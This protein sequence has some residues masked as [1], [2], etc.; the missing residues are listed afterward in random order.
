MTPPVASLATA[1]HATRLMFFALGLMTGTWGVHIPDLKTHYGLGAGSLSVVLLAAAAG[2]VL[3]LLVAGRVVQ[4]LGARGAALGAGVLVCLTVG[5]VLLPATYGALMLL[6]LVFG[7]GGAL[8]DV[9][10]NAEGS[11]LEA[12]SPR[13]IMSGLH[14]MF[15]VGGMSGAALGALLGRAGWTADVQLPVVAGLGALAVLI[16]CRGMLPVHPPAPAA[17]PDD[18]AG[19]PAQAPATV[20]RWLAVLCALGMLAEGAMYD[21]SVLYLA[22]DLG[23][24][25]DLAAWG[26]AS[27]SAAMAVARFGGD[28]VR[29]RVPAGRLLGLSAGL[30]AVAMAVVLLA[31]RVDVALVGYALA[32]VGL[33]NVVPILF[34]AAANVP[35][36]PPARGIARVSS[37]G[38][39]G[40]LVGPPIVGALAHRAS[41]T[42]GLSVVVVAAAV[43]A[44]AAPRRAG[45]ALPALRTEPNARAAA[46]DAPAD[47]T[48]TCRS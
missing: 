34:L 22:Q 8:F 28:A 24:R 25:P 45:S 47:P 33:A 7:V 30:S 26:Y 44:W 11:A 27:F 31:G 3:S 35:G 36:V 32:G 2:S 14:G 13:P 43:L 39:L 20:L 19:R 4:A 23:A 1:R 29:A 18:G 15:S 6:A 9:A 16:G 46:S 21:W 40:F 37:V 12:M 41:L 42:V 10:I 38:Y 5:I 17:G 48:A